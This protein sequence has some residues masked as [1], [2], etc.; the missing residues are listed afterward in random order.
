MVN[1][2]HGGKRDDDK[3]GLSEYKHPLEQLSRRLLGQ[4]KQQP[5]PQHLF[6][7]QLLRWALDNHELSGP[8]AGDHQRLKD[9]VALMLGWNPQKVQ[10]LLLND[11]EPESDPLQFGMFLAENLHS[12]LVED[13]NP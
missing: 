5:D 11:L 3:S 13:R 6:S 8:W 12:K 10:K 7:L 4:V 9:Q 1:D 2:P